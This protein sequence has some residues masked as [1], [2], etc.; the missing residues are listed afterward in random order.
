MMQKFYPFSNDLVFA[1]TMQNNPDLCRRVIER[2]LGFKIDEAVS[3][4]AQDTIT[5]VHGKSVRLDVTLRTDTRYIDVE[6]Q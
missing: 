5:A 4:V 1:T 2:I 3:V 6:M